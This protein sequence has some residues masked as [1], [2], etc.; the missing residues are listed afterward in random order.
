MVR[1]QHIFLVLLLAL[2]PFFAIAN[3]APSHGAESHENA[4]A[5]AIVVEH[6]MNHIADAN[7][8]HIATIDGHH[9]SLHLPCI[10]LRDGNLSIFNSAKFHHGEHEVEGYKLDPHTG[11]VVDA[12]TGQRSANIASYFSAADSSKFLDLSITK[13]VFTYLLSFILLTVILLIVKNAYVKNKN[14]SPKGIQSVIEP[15]VSFIMNDVAK[16]NIGPKYEKFVPFLL[17]LFFFI[18]CNNLI[19][20]IPFFPGSANTTGNI[21]FTCVLAVIAFVVININGNKSYWGHIFAMPG[22]PKWVLVILTPVEIVGM[23]IKPMAL[24]LR[25]FGN[26]L[27]GHIAILS[28]VSLIFIFGQMGKSITGA[29]V[30]SALAIPIVI[31]VNAMELFVA[32]LQAY[33]FTLLTAIFIGAAVEEH[34]HHGAEHH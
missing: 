7:E 25:L 30:G 33:V 13:N 9:Y 21:A 20:L 27:G 23:F 28:I 32:F 26:I 6:V 8:F 5:T 12:A 14:A 11:R 1:K 16:E 29:S 22:V 34:E 3:E 10:L 4:D 18:L 24:M 17:S 2:M 31:F 19:G 15:V